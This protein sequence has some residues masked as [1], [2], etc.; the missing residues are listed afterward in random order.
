LGDGHT[1]TEQNPAHAYALPGEY[2]IKLISRN[3]DNCESSYTGKVVVIQTT[4]LAGGINSLANLFPNPASGKIMILLAD[5][6][7]R[8]TADI[9]ITSLWGQVVYQGSM[10]GKQTTLDLSGYA[11]GQYLVR[12]KSGDKTVIKKLVLL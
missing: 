6:F 11:K 4:G 7:A 3:T 5:S 1:S 8:S 10:Q 9:Q 2:T 12:I